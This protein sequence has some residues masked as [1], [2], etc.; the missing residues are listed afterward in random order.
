M[1]FFAP[2]GRKVGTR[3]RQERAGRRALLCPPL[4]GHGP[5]GGGEAEVREGA[6][7]AWWSWNGAQAHWGQ[8]AGRVPGYK[9]APLRAGVPGRLR[10]R[11]GTAPGPLRDAATV[12]SRPVTEAYQPPP[13]CS[14]LQ[15]LQGPESRSPFRGLILALA[16]RLG[17]ALPA[18]PPPPRSGSRGRPDAAG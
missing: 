5:A 18:P 3:G 13:T 9:E 8:P 1:E 15:W 4:A 10:S 16:R 17:S 12:V 11:W 2:R 14:P 6:S 7:W